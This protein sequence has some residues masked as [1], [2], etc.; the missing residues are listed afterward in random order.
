M[1]TIART[2][3]DRLGLVVVSVEGGFSSSARNPEE[4][5][6]TVAHGE[7][8]GRPF[9]VTFEGFRTLLV[10]HDL[11]LDL[12][13]S[14][15]QFFNPDEDR[16]Y[17][18]KTDARE[19]GRLKKLLTKTVLK[20]LRD[21]RNLDWTITDQAIALSYQNHPL[22]RTRREPTP[23]DL[24]EL[25]GRILRVLDALDD[26]RSEVPSHEALRPWVPAITEYAAREGLALE[27]TPL[28]MRGL[29]SGLPLHTRLVVEGEVVS[30]KM[31]VNFPRAISEIISVKRR[32]GWVSKW[33]Q[34]GW[35]TG[36]T[37]FDKEWQVMC[38]TPEGFARLVTEEVRLLLRETVL[39]IVLEPSGASLTTPLAPE[40]VGPAIESVVAL[41]RTVARTDGQMGGAGGVYR[42]GVDSI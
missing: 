13:L 1:S 24:I 6:T 28:E 36:D 30:C 38:E 2:V 14:V 27:H 15:R 18:R 8:R 4:L 37:A 17:T 39:D 35:L 3:C 7:R 10:A 9:G 32:T 42:S 20:H 26:A 19:R 41:V 23:E 29:L 11:G 40:Q 12:G 22:F 25:L 33:F 5:M 31:K 16:G 34:A 21:A